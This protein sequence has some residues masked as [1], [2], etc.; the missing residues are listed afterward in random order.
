MAN[1]ALLEPA[2]SVLAQML[3]GIQRQFQQALQ[4]LIRRNS[5]EILEHEL[6]G[7][8]ATDVAE[9]ERLAARSVDEI[10]MT[11]VDDDE[12]ALDVEPRPPQFPGC[13]VKGVSRQPLI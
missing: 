11:I 6:L 5:D 1:A 3:L 13:L 10:A 9:L 4:Q 2:P 8:Q 12:I 7:E